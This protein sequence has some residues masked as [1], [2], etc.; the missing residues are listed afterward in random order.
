MLESTVEERAFRP[1]GTPQEVIREDGWPTQARFWL[2][3]GS[4]T[5][6][7]VFSSFFCDF[8]SFRLDQRPS[9]PVDV[10]TAGPSTPQIIALR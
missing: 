5:A 6:G 9:W 8:A 10:I 2:E 3:W 1:R 7:K 4:S